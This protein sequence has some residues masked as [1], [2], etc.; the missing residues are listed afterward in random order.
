[1]RLLVACP[2]CHRQY[3][4]AGR[5]IGKRFRCRC[6]EIVPISQPQGHDAAVVRCSSCGAPRSEGSA[7]CKFCGA[8][9]TTFL[10]SQYDEFGRVIRE[11]DIKAD[12]LFSDSPLVR[13]GRLSV[14]PLTAAQYKFLT[15]R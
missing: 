3:E 1:M 6:G 5:L 14:V 2:K 10:R 11:A 4:A 15:G 8:D 7:Q 12:K 9:F 13:Q